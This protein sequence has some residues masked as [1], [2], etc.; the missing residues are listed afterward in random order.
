MGIS[1]SYVKWCPRGCGIKLKGTS[2]NYIRHVGRPK[3]SY[4][5]TVCKKVFKERELR[6]Y[7]GEDDEV[8]IV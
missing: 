1:K 7:W 3:L 6:K 5:C 2:Q 8:S 4:K